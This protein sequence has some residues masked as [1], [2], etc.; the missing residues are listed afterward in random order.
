M[1][2]VAREAGVSAM[3][4]SR[5]INGHP[6]VTDETRARVRVAIDGL[7]YRADAA[8]RM[9]AGGR[10]HVLGVV[11][12]Q[13]GGYGP[14]VSLYAIESAARAAG[15]LVSFITV[16]DPTSANLSTAITSLRS[17][18]AEGVVVIA[19]LQSTLDALAA[20]DV[21]VPV[22]VIATDDATSDVVGVDQE[23]GARLATRHLLELGHETVHHLRGPRR[24]IDADARAD[25]WRKELRSQRRKIGHCILGDWT[26]D[27]GYTAGQRLAAEPGVTAVFAANDNM[28]VGLLLAFEE[29]GRR[30]PEDVSVVGFD[31]IAVAGFLKPPL[32]TVRQP[33]DTLARAAVEQVLMA[34][35]GEAHT[36]VTI[37]PRLVLRNSTAARTV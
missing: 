19:R 1:A 34:I 8:A 9:L 3:T 30:V 2:D 11:S 5:V 37:T 24:W 25:G 20:L 21:P 22:V 31:D 33:F 26:P 29:A 36:N 18:H 27:S 14:T 12:V 28:A 35:D 32:T 23:L 7:D 16:A 17:A 13:P 15:Q 6:S 4:V 10:S